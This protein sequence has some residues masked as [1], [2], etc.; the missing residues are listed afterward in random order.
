MSLLIFLIVLSILVVV[1][2]WGHFIT[3]KR[4][5]VGGERFSVGF[6]KKIFSRIHK[7]TEF[8]ISAIPLGGYVKLAGE[9]RSECKGEAD[10]FFSHPV[11]HRSLIVVMGPVV[12]ILFA[13][14]CFYLLCVTGFPKL[15][16]PNLDP[17]VGRTVMGSPAYV[18]GLQPGDRIMQIDAEEIETFKDMQEYIRSTEGQALEFTISRNETK[19]MQLM[20]PVRL[21]AEDDLE[22]Q[23]YVSVVGI[24]PELFEPRY[25]VLESFG[26]AFGKVGSILS[27]TFKGLYGVITGTTPAKDALAG[28]IGIFDIINDAARAGLSYLTLIVGIVSLNLAIVNLFP[29][30]VLD[31]GHLV[32]FAIEKLRKKPLSAKVEEGLVKVGLSLLICLMIFTLYNDMDRKGWFNSLGNMIQNFRSES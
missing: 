12:N 28:P 16:D 8:M 11:G 13:Y 3:A 4:L 24:E 19:I 9:D 17:V 26:K 1:H 21:L 25:G 32:F 5:G 22:E 6:G 29:I 30:P 10:E 14:L 15:F 2:E 23:A 7:G 20:T 31:G 18:A 27:F